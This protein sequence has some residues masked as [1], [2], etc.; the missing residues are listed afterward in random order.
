M[1]FGLTKEQFQYIQETVI[2]PLKS[3]G[4][5]VWIFGSRARGDNKKY[6]DLDIMVESR[7]DISTIVGKIQETLESE[8][9]PYK[10]DMVQNKDFA[11][12]YR[13]SFEMDK[14]Q[15]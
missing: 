5:T 15:P 14:K 1:K 12:S 4:A 13:E 9:F 8:N 3:N 7:E 2:D 11:E 6:S 10:V